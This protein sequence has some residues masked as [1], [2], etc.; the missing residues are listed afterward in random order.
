MKKITSFIIVGGIFLG[1]VATNI[2]CVNAAQSTLSSN[3]E[4]Q[5]LGSPSSNYDDTY[6]YYWE[7]MYDINSKITFTKGSR[8]VTTSLSLPSSGQILDVM[9]KIGE[10]TSSFDFDR[11]VVKSSYG[12]EAKASEMWTIFK[13]IKITAHYTMTNNPN[14]TVGNTG[15]YSV[16]NP[17]VYE[18]DKDADIWS[19]YDPDSDYLGFK[20]LWYHK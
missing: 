13:K 19:G 6:T 20:G 7:D 14:S 15:N 18:N 16:N 2:C 11:K 3:V 4:K 1:F 17:D 9:C 12:N 5:I 8:K 10:S